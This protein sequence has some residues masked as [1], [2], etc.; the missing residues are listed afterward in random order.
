MYRSPCCLSTPRAR[1][2][3][4]VVNT[5]QNLSSHADTRFLGLDGFRVWNIDGQCEIAHSYHPQGRSVS[6]VGWLSRTGL[7]DL[8]LT[9]SWEGVLLVWQ[10]MTQVR[11]AFPS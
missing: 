5:C 8:L 3:C 7:D 9:I 2:W 6:A 11:N 4:R 10:F 1:S